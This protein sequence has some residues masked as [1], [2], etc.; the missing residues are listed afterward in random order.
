MII[1]RAVVLA[2]GTAFA[3]VGYTTVV[4]V[5]GSLVDTPHRR[6]SGSRCWRT[7]LGRPGL[8][9][10]AAQRWSGLANRLAY[11]P[12][13]QPYEALSEFSRRLAET[14]TSAE[15]LP[16]VAEAAGRAVSARGATATLT[17]AVPG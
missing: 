2:V 13:A 15:L 10:A 9:A 6:A 7:A 17:R 16:A 8:P 5:V 14:P 11:G 1:N 3:A 12:R 4:V